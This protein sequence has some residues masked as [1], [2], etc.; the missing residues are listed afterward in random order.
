MYEFVNYQ[1][2]DYMTPAPR[3]IS[4]DTALRELEALFARH[5]FNGVPVTDEQQTLLG[6]ATKFDLLKAFTFQPTAMIPPYEAIMARKVADYMT[7][8]PVTTQP[9]MPLTRV[10]QRMVEMR[11]KSFPVVDD[12]RVVGVIAR[13]DILRALEDA[14]RAG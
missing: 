12:G 4:P 6:V 7:R 1:V 13:E 14:T 10:L 5:D 8:E 2:K 11:T 9:D 3:T